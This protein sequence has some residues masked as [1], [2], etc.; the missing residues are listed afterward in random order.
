MEKT[1][2]IDWLTVQFPNSED[3]PDF[4]EYIINRVLGFDYENYDPFG[5]NSGKARTIFY[6]RKSQFNNIEFEFKFDK[7]T[8]LISSIRCVL[9]GTGCKMYVK[10]KISTFDWIDEL[11]RFKEL[12]ATFS[13]IDLALDVF[14]DEEC[15]LDDIYTNYVK[16]GLFNTKFKNV[17]FILNQEV[18]NQIPCDVP[19]RTGETIYFGSLKNRIELFRFYN[20]TLEQRNSQFLNAP[21]NWLRIEQE[22]HGAKANL[23]VDK[24]IETNNLAAVTIGNLRGGVNFIDKNKK[25]IYVRDHCECKKDKKTFILQDDYMPDWWFDIIKDY[26]EVKVVVAQPKFEVERSIRWLENTV[27]PTNYSYYIMERA[28]SYWLNNFDDYEIEEICSNELLSYVRISFYKSLCEYLYKK[29]NAEAIEHNLFLKHYLRFSVYL[30]SELKIQKPTSKEN[31]KMF[32]T[33]CMI[34]AMDFEKYVSAVEKKNLQDNF[35]YYGEISYYF[36]D[37]I[38]KEFGYF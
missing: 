28:K 14:G 23:I 33:F 8:N 34:F 19:V 4:G 38:K 6:H 36:I 2:S 17:S 24:I 7:E 9:S 13:R 16:K 37:K 12:D 29:R 35:E 11:K 15:N 21:D 3:R 22:F 27:A 30:F 20:K 32:K 31:A 1:V 25:N 5:E 18:N 26:E 10:D